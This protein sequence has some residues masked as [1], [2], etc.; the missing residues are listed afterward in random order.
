MYNQFRKLKDMLIAAITRERRANAHI[1]Q[2]ER[3]VLRLNVLNDE[4]ET[5]NRRLKD[6]L[7]AAHLAADHLRFLAADPFPYRDNCPVAP[8][9][10]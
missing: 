4:L 6:R 10:D 1:R 3:K 9:Y 8:D 2:L 7:E 5:L